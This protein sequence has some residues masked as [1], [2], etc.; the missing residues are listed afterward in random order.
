MTEIKI[1]T[2]P[3]ADLDEVRLHGEKQSAFQD[4][5]DTR[6]RRMGVSPLSWVTGFYVEGDRIHVEY[7]SG[8]QYDSSEELDLTWDELMDASNDT[9]RKAQAEKERERREAYEKAERLARKNR[10]QRL[11]QE[12]EAARKLAEE[13]P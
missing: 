5:L 13:T 7:D 4:W 12:L 6:L 1:K 3:F 11:E 9:Y 10:V 2:Q 8:Y